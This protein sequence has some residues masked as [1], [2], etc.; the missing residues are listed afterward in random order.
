[1]KDGKR[2]DMNQWDEKIKMY[3]EIKQ[4]KCGEN[5]YI[6]VKNILEFYITEGC[7]LQIAPRD[8]IQTLV[9]MEWSMDEFFATG[10][11]TKFIDRL[12][13]SLGIHAST[14]KVMSVYEGSLVLNYEITPDPDSTP[15]E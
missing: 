11:T 9:R 5:R 7:T 2:V 6:G 10:G 12:A 13:G 15:E 14:I 3:G 1:L 4:R 8:A